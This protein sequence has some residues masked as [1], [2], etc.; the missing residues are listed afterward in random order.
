[1]SEQ[2]PAP[3]SYLEGDGLT[4]KAWRRALRDGLILG[5]RCPD[6]GHVT[7]APK[8]ACAR[9][10]ARDLGV[11]SLPVSGEVYTQ[12]TI[13]VAPEGFEGPYRVGVVDLGDARVLGRLPGSAE[14][15]DAVSLAGV[16]EADDR[17]APRFE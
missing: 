13:A 17:V 8:A 14:I 16:V 4:A 5:Q 6:C 7:A 2:Q 1:M 3:E 9:C 15:G 11:E 10:G 12:T